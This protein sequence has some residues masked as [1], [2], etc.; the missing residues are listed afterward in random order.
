[1]VDLMKVSRGYLV[2]VLV[3]VWMFF[4]AIVTEL[5]IGFV[6]GWRI[7]E[8]FERLYIEPYLASYVE[9]VSVGGLPLLITLLY[10]DS[11]STYGLR[12]EGLIKSLVLS[13]LLVVVYA[14]ALIALK[15]PPRLSHVCFN[16]DYPYN[17]W[18]ALL[19]VFAYGPLE[20]FFVIW[21]IVNTD[22][23]L[24]SDRLLSPGLVIT[25]V[26]FGLSHLL[27][28]PKAGYTN[29]I[30]VTVTF[31]ILGL[32]FKYTKNSIGPMI[33]WTILNSQ[34]RYLIVGCLCL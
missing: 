26:I 14:L 17:I 2:V 29:T 9:I 3:W 18:Y 31:L 22:L 1:M 32:I 15:G 7:D 11:P 30:S 12:K 25:T 24:K 23:A 27:S 13:L 19:G 4:G 21:L 16:L 5:I 6:K 20:V 33:A 34:V 10:G 8:I 28:A